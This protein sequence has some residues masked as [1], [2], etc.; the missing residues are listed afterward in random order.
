MRLRSG[1]SLAELMLA[2]WLFLFVL[3]GLAR[4]AAAQGRLSAVVSDRVRLEELVRTTRVVVGR[5]VRY[6]ATDDVRS[7]GPDSLAARG[8]RGAGAVCGWATRHVVVRYR[9]VRQPDPAKDSVLLIGDGQPGGA[10]RVVGT[11]P[12]TG[13]P[14]GVRLDL[15]RDLDSRFA[16]GVALLFESGTYQL[17]GG[18]LR[19]R[20]G[21]G[22]RQPLTEAVLDQGGVTSVGAGSWG[23]V[24]I[25]LSLL[26]DSLPRVTPR[27]HAFTVAPAP[28]SGPGHAGARP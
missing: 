5:E 23:P 12:A 15:D 28:P 2:S 14:G 20:L 6:L 8:L 3:L 19:Y 11:A 18:A 16:G 22:G 7:I 10:Y 1:V 21:H 26:D 17:S 25:G 24:R 4:F 27:D 13:C 9:G